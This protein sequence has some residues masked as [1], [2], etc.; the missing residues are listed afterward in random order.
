[1]SPDIVSNVGKAQVWENS[2]LFW[3][4]CRWEG[5]V[6]MEEFNRDECDCA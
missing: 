3:V 2:K 4:A 5:Q 6:V 1:M